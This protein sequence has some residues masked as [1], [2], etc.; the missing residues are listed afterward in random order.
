MFVI[1]KC[2]RFREGLS[3]S[4]QFDD[5]FMFYLGDLRVS[6]HV[7]VW[8]RVWTFL[9]RVFLWLSLEMFA[10]V[11]RHL[12]NETDPDGSLLAVTRLTDSDKFQPL[13]VVLKSQRR[14]PWQRPRYRATD[15]TLMQITQGRKTLRPG[16]ETLELMHTFACLI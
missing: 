5:H 7:R 8:T 14:W 2:I 15:F 9:F 12:V 6:F 4:N 10:K 13:G 16:T 1:V 3:K 11:T